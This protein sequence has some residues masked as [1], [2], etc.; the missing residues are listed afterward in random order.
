MRW[1]NGWGLVRRLSAARGVDPGGVSAIPSSE[2]RAARARRNAFA[3]RL[4]TERTFDEADQIAF[5]ALS[6]DHNPLHVDALAARRLIFG[7]QVV[8][9]IHAVLWALDCWCRERAGPGAL[10]G[11]R[12]DFQRPI[13]LGE[14]L[15][16]VPGAG[17]GERAAVTLELEGRPAVR[18]A[19]SFE[20]GG[21]GAHAALGDGP[22][23]EGAALGDGPPPEGACREWS[24]A[25]IAEA[26]GSLPLMLDRAA[27]RRLF[28]HAMRVLPEGQIATLLATT[29]LVGAECPGLHSLYS[30]LVLRFADEPRDADAPPRLD[31]AVAAFD[32]RF[33]SV[34]LE[35]AGPGASG[36]IRAFLRPPPAR[37]PGYGEVLGVVEAGSFAGRRALVVGGSRGLGEVT[38]KLLAAGGAEVGITYRSGAGDAE[39]VVR[40]ITA[41]GGAAFALPLDVLAP[42]PDWPSLL[43]EGWRPSHLYYFATPAITAGERQGFSAA[44]FALFSRCY[45]GGFATLVAGLHRLGLERA[46]YPSSVFV[47]EPPSTMLE[48]A[49]AKAAGEALCSFLERVHPGLVIDRP[50]LPRLV[51]DQTA[52]LVPAEAEAVLPIMRHALSGIAGQA[53]GVRMPEYSA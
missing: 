43:P 32:A 22:P 37:Q 7:R 30:Q 6:G 53:P 35:V 18:L 47:D 1:R 3:G 41:G 24:A 27:A 15:R 52:A 48:Y 8:H 12:A 49:A 44:R 38:A 31:Y 34:S 26:K 36:S 40:E 39:R 45:L 29:R 42:A 51:T 21:G 14:K 2:E 19:F 4:M 10:T 5:A 23:P 17:A 16:Y 28:P 20:D 9:G 11:I 46:F 33:N 13:G 50:R 25:T